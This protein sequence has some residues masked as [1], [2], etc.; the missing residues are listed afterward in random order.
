MHQDRDLD[1]AR[2]LPSHA[3]DVVFDLELGAV[4]EAMAAGDRLVF[5]VAER[6][7]LLGLEDTEAIFYRQRVLADCLEQAQVVRGIYKMAVDAVQAERKVWGFLSSSPDSILHRST[8]VMEIFLGVLHQLRK[9]ADESGTRFSSPG[10]ARF[11]AMLGDELDDAYFETVE[12]HLW[13]LKFKKGVVISSSRLGKGNTG[14]DYVLRRPKQRR[15]I[16]RI[17]GRGRSSHSFEVPPR[18]E[19]GMQALGELRARG[20]NLVA[21]ALAQSVEH[22][23]SFFTLLAHE[24]AFY[25]GCLNLYERLAGKGEPVCTPA[26]TAPGSGMLHAT[27]LYDVALSL[28]LTDRAVGN[29]LRADGKR[30]VVITGANQGGKSTLM[31]AIGLA[32][33]MMHAGMFVPAEAFG[34]EVVGGVFTHYKRE[35]DPGMEH[36]KL[37]EELSRM[38]R[39]VEQI[40]PGCL[41]L[42]NESFASTNEREGSEIGRQV[43]RAMTDAGVKVVLVTHLYD[44]AHGFFAS[45]SKV[46]LFL[47]AE[48]L[49][50]GRRTYKLH[51]GAPLP[52]SFGADTYRAVLGHDRGA[53][54]RDAAAVPA[55]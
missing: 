50:D 14:T 5:E 10:F 25:I 33:L 3:A 20:I 11:F 47:R 41:L 16:E 23:R 39:V 22:V 15:L 52:T 26:P 12:S 55:D 42:C 4:L 49:D 17:P 19:A 46:I 40:T 6:A 27:G 32:Q 38:H 1:L 45:G 53:V 7:L 29:D 9:V 34:A 24:L 8:Q 28:H 48:R 44:L 30:L 2:E 18:D 54:A 35:E 13:E 51:E 43:L 31:R 36:G 21:N 37:E